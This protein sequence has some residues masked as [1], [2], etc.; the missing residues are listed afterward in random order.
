MKDKDSM[1]VGVGLVIMIC[2][3]L[4]VV[5]GNG[6]FANLSTKATN[7]TDS[8]IAQ[9]KDMEIK[10]LVKQLKEKQAELDRVKSELTGANTKIKNNKNDEIKIKILLKYIFALS[11]S[12]ISLITNLDIPA[13]IWN[14]MIDENIA[15]ND[16]TRAKIA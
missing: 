9:Q 4:L 3:V 5:W 13:S 7:A 10:K 8:L 16:N 11:S 15:V 12:F 2:V 1:I 14:V 6:E